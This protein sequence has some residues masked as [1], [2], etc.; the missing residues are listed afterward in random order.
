MVA[1]ISDIVVLVPGYKMNIVAHNIH[2]H[3]L[4]DKLH[5]ETG[6]ESRSVGRV[7]GV[8]F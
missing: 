2:C 1:S 3:G 8:V 5:D 7:Q 6:H 4:E